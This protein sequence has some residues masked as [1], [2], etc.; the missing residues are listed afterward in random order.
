M[1][2][3]SEDSSV[4][5][6][7]YAREILTVADP[8]APGA[9]MED[10]LEELE[11]GLKEPHRDRTNHPFV[12]KVLAGK[13]TLRQIG[14]WLLQFSLWADQ[15][16]K[17]F[18]VVYANTPDPDLRDAYLE[19]IL[20]EERGEESKTA[21][22]ISLIH[23]ALEELGFSKEERESAE[24]LPESWA[25]LHWAEVRM[26]NRSFLEAIA[27][28]LAGER[29][30]PIV[31]R[32]LATGLREHYHVSQTVLA[33]FDVH[34]SEVEVAHGSI[35]EKVIRRYATTRFWQEK[36][37]FAVYHTAELYYRFFNVYESY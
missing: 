28:G 26:K 36:V 2:A 15:A 23:N 10:F 18:G 12:H 31:F 9:P 7:R 32:R 21:G 14:G 27:G 35:S 6:P 8:G 29:I 25:F 33:P 17:C 30:N 34:A 20:E 3:P 4:D 1:L 22:H 13:A 16:N 24:M 19:N 37:R 5:R 11:A